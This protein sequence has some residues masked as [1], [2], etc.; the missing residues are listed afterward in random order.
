MSEARFG[1]D[2]G[3]GFGPVAVE[4]KR[5]SEE[6]LIYQGRE[7]SDLSLLRGQDRQDAAVDAAR[8]LQGW[9]RLSDQ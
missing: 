8:K 1:A 9:V 6:G 3:A 4:R 2:V 5:G 7:E